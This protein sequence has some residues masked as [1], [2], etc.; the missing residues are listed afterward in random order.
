MSI[1]NRQ[2]AIDN[3]SKHGVTDINILLEASTIFENFEN[4]GR[5]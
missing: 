1:E 5:N 2:K 3:I 4:L